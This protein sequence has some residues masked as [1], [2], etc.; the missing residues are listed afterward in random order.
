MK[1]AYCVSDINDAAIVCPVCRRDL[2]LFKPLQERIAELEQK[3]KDG[4]TARHA[5]L[6]A[7]IAEL[8]ARHVTAIPA[9][10]V[11]KRNYFA[12]AL[13]VSL[14]SL[15]LLLAAHGL[16]IIVYDLKTIYLRIA[17][18]LLPLP[19]GFALYVWHP[20][21]LWTSSVIGLVVA[22]L[23]VI[24]MSAMTGYVDRVPVLPGNLR[25]WREFIEYS[26]SITFSFVTG[27]LLGKIRYHHSQKPA[28]PGRMMVLVAQLFAKDSE[29]ELGLQKLATKLSRIAGTVAPAISGAVSIYTGIKAFIGD[30]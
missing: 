20:R 25:E 14:L 8:E 9:A 23:A 1:C 28:R 16:I 2:Y 22:C 30:S 29:G 11:K 4:D 17:S 13:F 19:F 7:R 12:S 26:A 15:A 21:N 27:L 24:G 5:Q 6:E 10:L 18:L 3:L